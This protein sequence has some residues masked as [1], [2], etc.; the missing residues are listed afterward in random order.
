MVNETV[1]DHFPKLTTRR[2]V[3]RDIEIEDAEA[4][5]HMRSNKMINRFIPR[6]ETI[7]LESAIQLVDRT[8]KAFEHKQAIGFAGVLRGHHTIIGTCGLMNIEVEHRHAEIGGEMATEY[9]GKGIAQEAFEEIVR[10]G[11][12][13]L[14]LHTIEAK[15][16]PENRGA[17]HLLE[18]RGFKREGYF[19]D[20]GFFNGRYQDLA[21]YTLFG[22]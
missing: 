4:I 2:L 11:L 1:F 12:E 6:P 3:L 17:V 8:Q 16:N 5:M 20:R 9:W 22:D 10:F 7:E 19:K 15:V 18:Q 13:D 14:R 21:V